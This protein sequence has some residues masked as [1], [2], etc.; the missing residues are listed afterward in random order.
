[1]ALVARAPAEKPAAAPKA[2]AGMPKGFADMTVAQI[3]EAAPGWRKPQ[4]EAALE[5]ER[6][7][8]KRKGAISALESA[9]AA[10][11]ES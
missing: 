7:H 2:P 10:K 3:A 11:E 5:H 9:L 8:A 4:L 6:A 1:M